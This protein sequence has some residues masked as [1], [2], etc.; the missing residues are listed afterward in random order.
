MAALVPG[1]N[2]QPFRLGPDRQIRTTWRKRM[3]LKNC[4][5]LITYADSLGGNLRA[6]DALLAGPLDGLFGGVHILPFFPSSGDRGFAP[7]TYHEVDARFGDWGDIQRLGARFELAAD[8]M[9]N[10]VSRRSVFFQDFQR[11]GR[12]SDYADLFLTLDKVWPGGEPPAEDVARI[13]LRRPLHPF[14]DVTIEETGEVERIWAT[15]GG[16]DWTEQIDLDVR[17]PRTWQLLTDELRFFRNQGIR[18]V[19]LDAVGYVI[20]KPGTSCFMVE[21]ELYEFLDRLHAFAASI[22]LD[23]L[24]EV[25]APFPTQMKLAGRGYWVYDFVLP[26]LVLHA[27]QT[28]NSQKL[29]AHLAA[30]PARQ[31]TTLDCHD[32]IPVQPDLD[33]ILQVRES[34]AV[35]DRLLGLGANLNRL[36]HAHG[37]EADFDAHQVN[38]TYYSAVGADDDAYLAARAVQLF[39]PGIPQVYYTG[40]LA[41]ENDQAAVEATGEGRSINRHD[42]SSEEVDQAVQKPAVQRLFRL[43]RFRNAHPATGPVRVLDSD[44]GTLRLAW[45]SAACTCTMTVDLAT[46]RAT[47]RC[48]N[49][50]GGVEE[51]RA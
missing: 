22:G 37:Q 45:E 6:L 14:T 23:L 1:L 34:R 5:Q 48:V 38:I 36:L 19:R 42:Y 39:A 10:H 7:I 18:I 32:G 26:L 27:L 29:R 25:H 43:V 20:K 9:V 31:F 2:E 16:R 46:P 11:R 12:R 40:L 30:S 4:V 35:V 21:P 24:P 47:V 51:L 44:E 3:D 15:F 8:L 33:G 28:G 17:S 50:G 41:G 49:E 13:A